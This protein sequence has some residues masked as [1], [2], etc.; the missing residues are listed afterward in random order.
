MK[1]DIKLEL[2]DEERTM[3]YALDAWWEAMYQSNS[4][5]SVPGYESW[6]RMD[7][8]CAYGIARR[9]YRDILFD[10]ITPVEAAE[11]LNDLCGNSGEK[12]SK[13]LTENARFIFTG[14]RY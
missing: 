5:S 13:V 10:L 6:A 8:D 2:E 9:Y 14:E 3:L 4:I 12:P 11:R 1:L 7:E